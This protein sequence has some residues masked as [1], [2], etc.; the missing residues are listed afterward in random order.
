M[1]LEKLTHRTSG[2]SFRS[3]LHPPGHRALVVFENAPLRL[4]R[5]ND[6]ARMRA[7][8]QPVSL[9][10]ISS[11]ASSTTYRR[12]HSRTSI[13]PTPPGPHIKRRNDRLDPQDP[14]ILAPLRLGPACSI[15]DRAR[16]PHNS[17]E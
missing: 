14:S 2:R 11:T 12:L 6:L 8:R 17:A 5:L 15:S 16:E 10:F 9:S 7:S 1:H 4:R 13:I 3:T